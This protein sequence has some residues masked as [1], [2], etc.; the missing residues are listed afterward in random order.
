MSDT[1]KIRVFATSEDANKAVPP[2]TLRK[3][4]IGDL[5]LCLANTPEGFKAI[6]DACPHQ[7]ASLSGGRLNPRMQ[8]I[9]PLH[10]YSFSLLTGQEGSNRTAAVEIYR[11]ETAEEGIFVHLPA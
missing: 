10:Q 8:V 6:A 4:R 2:G 3:L 9:C 11:V 1:K 5:S 7:G